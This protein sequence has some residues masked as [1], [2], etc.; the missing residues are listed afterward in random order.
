MGLVKSRL[1]WAG[2][3]SARSLVARGPNGSASVHQVIFVTWATSVPLAT[4][5]PHNKGNTTEDNCTTHT[6]D[7][8]DD[9]VA[10]LGAEA[11]ATRVTLALVEAWGSGLLR[12]SDRGREGCLLDGAVADGDGLGD[13][14]ERCSGWLGLRRLVSLG[15]LAAA[16][17][18]AAAVTRRW[19]RGGFG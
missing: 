16:A 10:V 3:T 6:D 7:D 18:V 19:R 11:R 8:T 5:S 1:E 15:G 9:D 12:S 14:R 13:N 17:A 4:Q 2:A